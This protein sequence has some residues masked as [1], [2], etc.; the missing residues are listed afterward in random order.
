MPWHMLHFSDLQLLAIPDQLFAF[1]DAYLQSADN[2]CA[3]LCGTADRATY[4]HGA[5]VMSLTFHALELFLKA[6]ILRKAPTEVVGGR[7]GHD[8]AVLHKRYSNL[9]P[10]K[11]MQFYI[12]FKREL[13]DTKNLD[14]Q[15]AEELL[16]YIQEQNKATPEDQLHRYP[17]DVDGEVWE[18]AF[19]F[20]PNS[21]SKILTELRNELAVVKL[22]MG[23]G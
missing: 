11:A 12:P 1:S 10:G 3:T 23:G 20:E 9:Y 8:L 5:V 14:P 22:H 4:A 19:G 2:L 15:V 21:F 7:T 13:P 6:A 16:S 18:G 17:I